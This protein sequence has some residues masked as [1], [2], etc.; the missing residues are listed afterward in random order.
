MK[1]QRNLGLVD[2]GLGPPLKVRLSQNEFMK[3]SIFQR[4]NQKIKW[5]LP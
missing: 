5:I 2:L 1:F 3:S 4:T